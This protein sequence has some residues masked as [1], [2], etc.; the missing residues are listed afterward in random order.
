[1]RSGIDVS[2]RLVVVCGIG[3]GGFEPDVGFKEENGENGGSGSVD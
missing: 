1:M 2:N 3:S